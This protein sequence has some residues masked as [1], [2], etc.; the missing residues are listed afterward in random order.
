MREWAYLMAS[1]NNIA[2]RRL[3]PVDNLRDQFADISGKRRSRMW[4]YRRIKDGTFKT[5]WIGPRQ[6]F[7]VDDP[8]GKGSQS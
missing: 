7:D 6:F 4:V 8:M 5:Y 2:R 1:D 3:A